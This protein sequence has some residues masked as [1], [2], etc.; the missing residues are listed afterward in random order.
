MKLKDPKITILCGSSVNWQVRDTQI[1]QI[2]QL[3]IGV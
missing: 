2:D 3:A 1:L